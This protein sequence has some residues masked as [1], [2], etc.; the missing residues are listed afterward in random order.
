[1]APTLQA[2]LEKLRTDFADERLQLEGVVAD[3]ESS[4]AAV[5][6]QLAALKA[7][8]QSLTDAIAENRKKLDEQERL[9]YRSEC[10]LAIE[11]LA[12][13]V[14]GILEAETYWLQLSQLHEKRQRLLNAKPELEENV[15][16]FR[17]FDGVPDSFLNTLPNFHR[18]M[19]LEA[20]EKLRVQVAPYLEIQHQLHSL[21][22]DTPIRLQLLVV[23]DAQQSQI[24]WILPRPVVLPPDRSCVFLDRLAT[25]LEDAV[26]SVGTIDQFTL[27]DVETIEWAGFTGLAT[28]GQFLGEELPEAEIISLVA[29]H[30]TEALGIASDLLDI[31]ITEMDLAAWAA[32]TQT[33]QTV[34]E[35]AAP[36]TSQPDE[37][38]PAIADLSQGW[39]RREDIIAWQRPVKVAPGSLWSEQARRLRTMLM[40][41][42]AKGAVG[43]TGA[44]GDLLWKHAPEPHR[45]H[46]SDGISRLV[47]TGVLVET[48]NNGR[49]ERSLAVNP[50]M[51]VEVQNLINRDVT[52][53]WA[54]IVG[55]QEGRDV[56]Q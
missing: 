16:D 25:A 9:L 49:D 51:M 1:M 31:R 44:S 17:S 35:E 10:A 5:Q 11:S 22:H 52:A 20:Q 33:I 24:S 45:R 19:L 27:N 2:Q 43:T 41:M 38:V 28:A 8:L 18:Q 36:E 54:G 39:Y 6:S 32:G 42:L 34:E 15:R 30:L 7:Q 13:D 3:L 37:A 56:P 48:V 12:E 4:Q 21:R 14:E 29:N 53:F 55:P 50:A 47:E 23:R 26:L 46:L 40:R